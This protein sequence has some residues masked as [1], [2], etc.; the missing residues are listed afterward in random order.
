MS[1]HEKLP[2]VYHDDI[3]SQPLGALE[4][5]AVVATEFMQHHNSAL[6]LRVFAMMFDRLPQA[7]RSQLEEM[8][9]RI[10]SRL[11]YEVLTT[12]L[13]EALLKL[14]DALDVAGSP[15]VAE[16]V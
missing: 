14:G 10:L 7:Q 6:V 5:L 9:P 4:S 12:E 8:I 15:E 1:D 11:E 13:D 3:L 16:T 2:V